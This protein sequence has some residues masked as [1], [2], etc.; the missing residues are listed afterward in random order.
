MSYI[1]KI[2]LEI[3]CLGIRDGRHYPNEKFWQIVGE[4]G[5]PVTIGFDAH[6]ASSGYDEKSLLKAE[7]L[8]KKYKLN[9]IGKPNLIMLS[10][11]RTKNI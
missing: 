1:E 8:I 2:P 6:E 5:A 3:N 11:K 9:Y 4:T 7:E 10:K